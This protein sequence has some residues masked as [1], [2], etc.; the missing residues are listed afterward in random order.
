MTSTL[1][2]KQHKNEDISSCIASNGKKYIE[3]TFYGRVSTKV[4]AEDSK[5]GL[6]RQKTKLEQFQ[7]L[8]PHVKVVRHIE[9]ALSGNTPNRHDWLIEGLEMER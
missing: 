9:E 3:C 7:N 4:Q 1:P 6:V 2:Q 5:S 8:N